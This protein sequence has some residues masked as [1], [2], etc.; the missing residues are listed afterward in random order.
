M[1]ETFSPALSGEIDDGLLE[2][3]LHRRVVDRT[4][5]IPAEL[6]R[7]DI[8]LAQEA[9]ERVGLL[10]R[11]PRTENCPPAGSDIG[12]Q[13]VLAQIVRTFELL[14]RGGSTPRMK[15]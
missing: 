12:D 11:D 14:K 5:P 2:P 15:K 8:D 1:T 13:R 3:V 9:V 6:D 7:L 10:C 4:P